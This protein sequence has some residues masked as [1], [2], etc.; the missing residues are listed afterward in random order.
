MRNPQL[1]VSLACLCLCAPAQAQDFG[2]RSFDIPTL[3][4]LGHDMHVQNLAAWHASDALE[5]LHARSELIQQKVA[6]WIVEDQPEGTLVRFIRQSDNG[7]EAAYD[8]QYPASV[9][10]ARDKPPVTEPKDRQL[11]DSEKAQ[12]AARTLALKSVTQRCSDSYNTV[13]LKDPEG[14]GW[15]A[16]ALAVTTNPDMIMAGGHHRLTV[17]AD[18]TKV[19]Q[20]DLLSRSCAVMEKASGPD[21]S[22]VA[23]LV[24]TQLVSNVPVETFVFLNLEY[25]IP[26]IVLTPDRTEWGIVNG[27]IGRIGTVGEKAGAP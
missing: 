13:V 11:T 18:G 27:K 2:I 21:G 15:L 14:D 9:D 1:V 4:K 25:R 5:A 12:F 3:E 24:T 16:W 7:P 20:M 22:K 26:I 6:G 19:L 17:S 23:A 10:F 8:I